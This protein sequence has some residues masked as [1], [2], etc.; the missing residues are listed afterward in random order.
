MLIQIHEQSKFMEM[1]GECC[2]FRND[3]FYPNDLE[4]NAIH[5]VGEQD[6]VLTMQT[7]YC[8]MLKE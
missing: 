3:V 4:E 8:F 7:I 5:F 2:L 6:G 1:V